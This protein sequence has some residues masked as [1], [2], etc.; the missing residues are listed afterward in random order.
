MYHRESYNT[1]QELMISEHYV[2]VQHNKTCKQR[3]LFFIET[4]QDY[5]A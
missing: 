2:Y 3:N 4:T 5:I 1:E